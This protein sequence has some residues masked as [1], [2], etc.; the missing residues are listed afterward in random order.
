MGLDPFCDLGQVLALLAEVVLH[1]EVDE[2]DDWLGG[3]KAELD[4]VRITTLRL[5]NLE[6]TFSLIN[7]ISGVVHSP[8]L[9]GLSCSNS[10]RRLANYITLE[11]KTAHTALI[12]AVVSSNSG[13]ILNLPPAFRTIASS[14]T[15]ALARISKSF[16]HSSLW[17]VSE[18]YHNQLLCPCIN[19][20]NAYLNR[21]QDQRSHQRAGP[22]RYQTPY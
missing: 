12:F 19:G 4:T 2:V 21:G 14:A 17:I 20:R 6:Q 15:L 22:R 18:Q 8:S 9:T 16:L 3:D 11:G 10:C 1:C 7:S 5:Q 13:S